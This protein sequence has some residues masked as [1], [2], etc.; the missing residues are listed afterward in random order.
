M[1]ELVG[2]SPEIIRTN[3]KRPLPEKVA[4]KGFESQSAPL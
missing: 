3:Y 2:N 4:R 1:V